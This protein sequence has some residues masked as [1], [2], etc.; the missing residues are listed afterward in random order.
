MA[1]A[2]HTATDGGSWET[3]EDLIFD[4][5]RRKALLVRRR[6]SRLRERYGVN[7]HNPVKQSM[8]ETKVTI[9]E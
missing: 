7:R 8:R 1:V 4:P 6:I 9:P 2:G 3:S 5:G